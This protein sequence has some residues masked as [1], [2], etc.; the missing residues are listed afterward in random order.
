M[1][2]VTALPLSTWRFPGTLRTY[3]AEVLERLA[4][5]AAGPL[6][7]VAP[8]GSGKT[9]LGLLL[10]ARE[11]HR[12]LVLS[13]TVTIRQQWVRTAE[14][15]TPEAAA[16]SD[17]PSQIGDLTAL[18]YQLLSVTGDGSPFDDLARAVWVE[19]LTARGRAEADASTWLAELAVD[20][21][22]RYRTGI[23]TRSRRLRSRFARRRPAE[24]A[25][26]L[27]PNAVALID[28][29]VAAGVRTVVLDECH[30]LLDHW[31]IVVAYLAGRIRESGVEPLLIGLTATLPSPDDETEFENYSQLLG[32][33]DYEVPTP[34]VVK[35]GHLAPYRDHV[36]F[37]EPTPAEAGFIRRHEALLHDMITRVLSTPDA[38]SYLEQQLQPAD[39][40]YDAAASVT[41]L[42]R[43]FSADFTLARSCAVVL[44]E[45]A[46]RHP[47]IPAIPPVLLD[48]CTTDDLLT[49]LSR[50]AQARLLADPAAARQWE[51][52][53]R[54]LADFGYALTD[55]G[56]RRGRNPVESTLALSAAKD[57]A[58][59]EILRR[60][61]DGPDG[62]R[63]RA[64]VVTD[65]VEHGNNR[66]L[67]GDAPAGALRTFDLLSVDDVTAGLRPV[68]LTAQHLR[69][70]VEDAVVLAD[71]LVELL[72]AP[73]D[74]TDGTGPVRDLEVRGVGSGRVVAAV[75]ELIRRGDVRL[76]V[77]TRGLLG[78]GWDC[79]A[80]NTLIDLTTV[81]TSS[82]TQQ[83]RGRTLRLDPAWPGKVAHNW[84]VVCSIPSHVDLDDSSEPARLR[85]RH[86]HLW[87]LSADGDGR[88]VSGLG[89]ALPTAAFDMWE[90]VLDKD[91]S[92]SIDDLDALLRE[93]WP[94][95]SSTRT[96]WR[97]GDRYEPRERQVVAIRRTPRAPLLRTAQAARAG[98]LGAFVAG[99]AGVGGLIGMLIASGADVA[100]LLW[101]ALALAGG[102]V[103]ATVSSLRMLARLL[104][105]RRRPAEIYRAAAIAV[106]RTLHDAE[107][108][109]RVD[110]A[111]IVAR[112]DT[113][114]P[115]R[116]HIELGGS[117]DDAR[118]IA[119][120]V[121]ELFAPVR[122]P[123]FLLRIDSAG[124]PRLRPLER[125]ADRLSP[126]R[127]LLAV[128][129]LIARRRGDAERFREHWQALI[130]TC[131]LHELTG[132]QGLAL[133]RVARSA[134]D[135]L[136]SAEPRAR[137][138]G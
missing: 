100:P 7:I 58:A 82:G 89:H 96:E 16:V 124:L 119:D 60:E 15:L 69:V 59:V 49:V 125:L 84:S 90:R 19:E 14:S 11:G 133:L 50:F 99:T 101:I 64:V 25:R 17:D 66:G 104:R 98:A 132:T 78:E 134:D 51:H 107:R 138:W 92:A 8:P 83:L 135:R 28:R 46:P 29:L 136:D 48:R 115:T 27:H 45:V 128:P 95:R 121:E 56:I 26:V 93:R 86:S 110:E 70:R 88:I 111:V 94:T 109:G 68:L 9:L 122:T 112:P 73:V 54:S 117:A 72:G 113:A 120:A 3:Q 106:A 41:R 130:G 40:S 61:L 67:A 34:A 105:D 13:P 76:L 22:G 97:I 57:H 1:D 24:L 126:G 4:P 79:P 35:E 80:V 114:D 55:R 42:D 6:H 12:T 23:R 74:V 91:T 53:R 43:A 38:V 33:V 129:R 36:L 63:I 18:T 116:I 65:F 108:I 85:R 37:T 81:A 20:N 137:V 31:A 127:T 52:V 47:L 71:A 102:T 30:H 5:G 77:G 32:E 87:G 10:A 39:G 44:R 21:P 103:A 2:P 131:T 62:D 118:V 123:R 75:S